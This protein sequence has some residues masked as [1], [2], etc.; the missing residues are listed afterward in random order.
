MTLYIDN[1]NVIELREL[2]NSAT[3]AADTGATV[4]VTVKDSAGDNVA[5]ETWP[6][7]LTHASG[8]TYRGT[9]SDAVELVEGAVYTSVVSVTGSGGQKAVFNCRVRAEVRRCE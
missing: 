4:S 5:G 8:G 7:S 9:L 1:S 3:G 2:K 6:V